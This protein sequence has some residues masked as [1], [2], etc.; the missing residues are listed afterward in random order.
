[1]GNISKIILILLGF[2][3]FSISCGSETKSLETKDIQGDWQLKEAFRDGKKTG[4][5]ESVYFNFKDNGTVNTNFNAEM[6]EF[7]S[8]YEI[9]EGTIVVSGNHPLKINAERTLEDELILK[10]GIAN[11]KFKLVLEPAEAGE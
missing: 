2:S 10:T 11:A 4:T 8:T 6:E 3:F 9:K 1:M 7:Q 5:L